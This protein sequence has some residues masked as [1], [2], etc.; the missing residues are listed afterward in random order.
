MD[1]SAEV[2]TDDDGVE[3]C[4]DCDADIE[5]DLLVDDGDAEDDE[6]MMWQV[7]SFHA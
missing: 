7:N 4:D 5:S 6:E 2:W 1:G 3:D